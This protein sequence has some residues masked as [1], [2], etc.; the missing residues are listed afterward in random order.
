MPIKNKPQMQKEI[1]SPDDRLCSI[2]GRRFGN[3]SFIGRHCPGVEKKW[4]DTIFSLKLPSE[5]IRKELIEII[6]DVW[7]TKGETEKE[8]PFD[9]N[10]VERS[11][12][13]KVRR[14]YIPEVVNEIIELFPKINEENFLKLISKVPS[15]WLEKAKQR[16]EEKNNIVTE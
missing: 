6:T 13:K 10:A 3:H 1:L 4:D 15:G 16:R 8:H 7:A 5:G 11:E 12:H 9:E 2:C 14:K